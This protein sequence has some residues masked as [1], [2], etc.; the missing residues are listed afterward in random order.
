MQI[1][2]NL[3]HFPSNSIKIFNISTNS[4]E[5]KA[6]NINITKT[7]KTF[8]KK[9]IIFIVLWNIPKLRHLVFVY[10]KMYIDSLYISHVMYNFIASVEFD[11]SKIYKKVQRSKIN[12]FS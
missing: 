11:N 3:I 2:K 4:I 5:I 8:M 9:I 12:K 7:N 1:H 6:P 10:E